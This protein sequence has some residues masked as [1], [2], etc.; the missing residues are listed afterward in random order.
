VPQ[1]FGQFNHLTIAE[2]LR[3]EDK[4]NA[5]KEILEGNVTE[6]NLNTLDDD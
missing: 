4:L 1:I 2:A 5:L 6:T 3:V